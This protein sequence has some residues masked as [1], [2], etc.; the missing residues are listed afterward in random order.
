VGSGVTGYATYAVTGRSQLPGFPAE[1][2][3]RRR[4]ADFQ[5]L[6]DEVLRSSQVRRRE[7]RI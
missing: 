2:R 4:F 5:W 3:L 1:I 7:R 6:Y